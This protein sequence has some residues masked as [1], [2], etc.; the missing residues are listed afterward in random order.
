MLERGKRLRL[1]LE[2]SKTLGIGGDGVRQEFHGDVAVEPRVA[3]T[4][5]LA[6]PSRSERGNDFVRADAGAWSECHCADGP[7]LYAGP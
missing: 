5:D 7:I 4:V 6:H 2:P 1:T 3:R